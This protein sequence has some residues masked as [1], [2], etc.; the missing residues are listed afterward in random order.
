MCVR[1]S[2]PE[3][4]WPSCRRLS[5]EQAGPGDKGDPHMP[6][7]LL[8]IQPQSGGLPAAYSVPTL[9]RAGEIPEGFLQ[10]GPSCG[11]EPSCCL[12]E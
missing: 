1:S 4:T 2:S 12:L 3:T 9:T 11:R 7:F 6:D 10:A 5:S 8:L